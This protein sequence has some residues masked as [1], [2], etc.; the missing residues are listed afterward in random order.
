MNTLL[1][2]VRTGALIDPTGHGINDSVE[3][4]LRIPFPRVYWE[5]VRSPSECALPGQAR[6][7]P[8]HVWPTQWHT[9]DRLVGMKLLRY[10]NFCGRGYVPASQDLREW[11]VGKTKELF[12]DQ[13]EA[14]AEVTRVFINRKVRRPRALSHSRGPTT[15]LLWQRP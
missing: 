5:Q 8:C 7:S 14:A 6:A 4:V 2:D 9:Q 13:P 3:F 12:R 15:A 1:Y 11:I 10:F